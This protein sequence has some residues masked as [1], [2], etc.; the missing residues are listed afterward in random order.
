[1]FRQVNRPPVLTIPSLPSSIDEMVE[2]TFDADAFDPDIPANTLTF[3]LVG[4]PEGA[5]IDPFTGVFTWTPSEAQGPGTY[6]FN[7]TVS[8]GSLTDEKEITVTVNEVNSNPTLTLPSL[9]SSINEMEEWTFTATATDPDIPA[10]TLTFSLVGAPEGASIDPFTGVFTWT[11]SEAQGPGT[12]TF[13]VTVSDGSLTDEK[14]I[15]VTVNEVNSNP[16]LTLPSLPSSINEMEEW[17]FT[18]T[19]TDPDIP[20]NTLT[21]SLVGA[22]EGASIDPFTGVFTW[23]PSEAQGPGTYTFNVTVSDGSLT[24]EKEITVTVNEVNM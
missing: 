12:Y 6:T 11:P 24:D 17:T 4:A 1:M 19:A 16:T 13:N 21:F 10:N 9:P 20:A 7:V 8:D 23:T 14:E 5:S 15:T 2:W 22:P 3:S 18:A